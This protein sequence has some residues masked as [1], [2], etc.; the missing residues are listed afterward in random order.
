MG[1]SFMLNNK[2]V[3][4]LVTIVILTY[5]AGDILYQAIDSVLGQTYSNMELI[6]SD[7]G[8]I[9]FDEEKI[10]NYI[11][12]N[13]GVNIKK[14]IVRQNKENIGTVKHANTV[15]S[16]TTGKYIIE[17]ACDD[18]FYC[19]EVVGKIIDKMEKEN[20]S[21]LATRRLICDNDL[22]P[23]FFWPHIL[24]RR[25]VAQLNTTY[26]QHVAFI[27]NTFYDMVSGSA[28]AFR[29]NVFDEYKYDESYILIEDF[30][31][32]T[33]YSWDNVIEYS[34]DIVS[35]KYRLGGCSNTINQKVAEDMKHYNE[36]DR[37]SHYSDLDNKT[38]RIVEYIIE[39]SNVLSN[40][41]R[42]GLY[43]KY[44]DILLIKIWY[45]IYRR[46]CMVF[47]QI[48]LRIKKER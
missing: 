25:K 10:D 21:V 29:K 24:E 33:K 19:N 22:K 31:F 32:F 36:S 8:S 41:E 5:N 38:K 43:I 18:V 15:Y 37:I 16:L 28:T 1:I 44:I 20:I 30:P 34:H 45:K 11:E 2:M 27:T 12:K 4:P 39:R 40:S 23:L 7:D 3:N 6:V 35:I 47:D 26:K 9:F 14:W 13:H 17:L 46:L 48:Y 42:L